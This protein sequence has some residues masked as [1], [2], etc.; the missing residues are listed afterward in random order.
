VAEFRARRGL[1]AALVHLPTRGARSSGATTPI[2]ALTV[3]GS[4]A[5]TESF[6]KL[7]RA[8]SSAVT[9]PG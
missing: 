6:G 3:V 2:D 9:S 8:G 1:P 7:L 5:A 4:C